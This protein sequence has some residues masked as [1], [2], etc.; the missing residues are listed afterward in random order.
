MPKLEA[1]SSAISRPSITHAGCTAHW[2]MCPQLTMKTAIIEPMR[3]R[4][5]NRP[6]QDP[7]IFS[8]CSNKS[9]FYNFALGKNQSRRASGKNLSG[10][11][12]R[13]VFASRPVQRKLD[14]IFN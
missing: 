9:I 11:N 6:G 2:D 5:G 3:E 12:R 8:A 14:P 1:R 13:T 10:S 4:G 7:Q